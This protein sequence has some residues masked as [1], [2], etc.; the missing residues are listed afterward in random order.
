MNDTIFFK[1]KTN[2]WFFLI[3]LLSLP[4]GIV[5]MLIS[6]KFIFVTIIAII[7]LL[8]QEENI[9]TSLRGSFFR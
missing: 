1:R 2:D 4:L 3:C 8:W 7:F 9:W 6:W 5:L